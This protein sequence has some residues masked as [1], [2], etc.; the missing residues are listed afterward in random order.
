M[1]FTCP[2]GLGNLSS[3]DSLA[4]LASAKQFGQLT[5][6]ISRMNNNKE[7][8]IEENGDD[9]SSL[10]SDNN[11]NLDLDKSMS[12]SE[13]DDDFTK[14]KP[15][16]YFIPQGPD[17]VTYKQ[18]QPTYRSNWIHVDIFNTVYAE[19]NTDGFN[20][21]ILAMVEDNPRS[22]RFEE[23]L[24]S[25]P[26][27][28]FVEMKSKDLILI[29]HVKRNKYMCLF[30]TSHLELIEL[31]SHSKI[32]CSEKAVVDTTDGFS[33]YKS[34]AAADIQDIQDFI[35]I[36]YFKI[37]AVAELPLKPMK[38]SGKV[39]LKQPFSTIS[40]QRRFTYSFTLD[41]IED[42]TSH[43]TSELTLR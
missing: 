23:R 30:G 34:V 37:E 38:T 20:H 13:T 2:Q 21:L 25:N 1:H 6:S 43:G 12:E 4:S 24:F 32:T 9:Y 28:T 36:Y 35:S 40:H 16:T 7:D 31:A 26:I 41:K 33:P 8:T 14:R 17:F 11:N 15:F 27:V 5:I 3:S 18:A 22:Y 10:D 42:V 19:V 29:L 39:D